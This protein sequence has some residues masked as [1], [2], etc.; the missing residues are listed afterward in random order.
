MLLLDKIPGELKLYIGGYV[1]QTLDKK[2]V[3]AHVRLLTL[4]KIQ[5]VHPET[6]AAT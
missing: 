4:S 1:Q 3:I 2:A 5:T 6:Q